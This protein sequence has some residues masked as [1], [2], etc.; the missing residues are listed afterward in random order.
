MREGEANGRAKL[1][2]D[3]LVI[4]RRLWKEKGPGVG[5]RR[6]LS[7]YSTAALAEEYDM[8]QSAMHAALTGITWK[9]RPD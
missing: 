5:N 2:W 4:L 9:R 6:R 1:N 7:R 8:S 3:H